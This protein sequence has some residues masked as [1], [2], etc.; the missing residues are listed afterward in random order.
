MTPFKPWGAA[1]TTFPAACIL[2]FEPNW[3]SPVQE[4]LAWR[5]ASTL[6][7]SG[8]EQRRSLRREPRQSIE[9][10][11]A[12]LPGELPLLQSILWGWANST[13]A[14]P[15][16][17]G[18][19]RLT[20]TGTAGASTLLLHDSPETLFQAGGWALIWAGTRSLEAVKIA[21]ITG[22][23]LGLDATL[24]DTWPAGTAIAPLQFM[25]LQ[26]SMEH[27]PLT[28]TVTQVSWIFSQEPGH[29]PSLEQWAASTWSEVFPTG[30]DAAE[31]RN[32]FF[33]FPH[34]W[35][36]SPST[37]ISTKVSV[38]DPG[39]SV[40]SRRAAVDRPTPHWA[41]DTL[42]DG[43]AATAQ[44]RKFLSA[45]AG[46][47]VG[48]WAASPVADIEL[49][50]DVTGTT[51]SVVDNGQLAVPSP[52]R[53]GVEVVAEGPG[54]VG[55]WLTYDYTGAVQSVEVPA[56]AK[57]AE[58]RAWGA[59]GG[60]VAAQTP[61]SKPV[62]APTDTRIFHGI[63][64]GAGALALSTVNVTS[65]AT[66]Q[67]YVGQGGD[68]T[69]ADEMVAIAIGGKGGRGSA[70]RVSGSATP[71]IVAGG[72]GGGGTWV[73]DFYAGG[74]LFSSM[75]G[76]GGATGGHAGF[77]GQYQT[78]PP[79]YYGTGG[80][81][82]PGGAGGVIGYAAGVDGEGA[83]GTAGI[84]GWGAVTPPGGESGNGG[85]GGGGGGYGGG[86]SGSW[87]AGGN[88]GGG[89]GNLAQ[90][91]GPATYTLGGAQGPG[92]PGTAW[93]VYEGASTSPTTTVQNGA[94]GRVMI[95]FRSGGRDAIRELVSSIGATSITLAADPL[96]A[97]LGDVVRASWVARAR[98]A[99]DAITI[100]HLTDRVATCRLPVVAVDTL[101]P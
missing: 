76:E 83:P 22:N 71:L 50:A 68:T 20:N 21:S 39:L 24:A 89:G 100:S 75:T 4:T 6:T 19:T 82:G 25:Q 49:T 84:T 37:G 32:H 87:T 81:P 78:S 91:V 15:L 8:A 69:T 3:S 72:G 36:G 23:V 79:F 2:P 64:G 94:N 12:I 55:E 40:L 62:D 13:F 33:S 77:A 35:A 67:V 48:F 90:S 54:V 14:V 95:R 101:A 80:L 98:L 93:H 53:T 10:T 26:D 34:N 17:Y 99:V 38:F 85:A 61:G 97:D 59:G 1:P 92:A 73:Q 30:A 29:A 28:S 58:I 31:P 16:W 43:R 70:V 56:G 42:L 46:A 44:L 27:T 51:L 47:T 57:V 63:R 65:G 60:A 41:I 74:G 66:L 18:K 52:L 11:S 96:N 9:F 5:M 45:H 88:G 7:Q 86:G